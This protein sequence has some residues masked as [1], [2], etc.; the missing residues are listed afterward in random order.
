WRRDI[1]VLHR[2]LDPDEATLAPQIARGMP[3]AA[4]CEVLGGIHGEAVG[5]RATE[6]LLRWI[7]AGALVSQSRAGWNRCSATSTSYSRDQ[8]AIFYR[9]LGRPALGHSGASKCCTIGDRQ[10]QN[11]TVVALDWL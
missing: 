1:S 8:F 7:D 9:A 2:T 3:F 5:E 11:L 4:V 6:L 10:S